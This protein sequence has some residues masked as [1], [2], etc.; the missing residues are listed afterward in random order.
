LPVAKPHVTLAESQ[1]N[2]TNQRLLNWYQLSSSACFWY[3]FDDIAEATERA[4][5]TTNGT[6]KRLI[7][8]FMFELGLVS[9]NPVQPGDHH[10]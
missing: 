10:E 4:K 9:C 5:F 7:A 1:L 3:Q 2:T 6:E 8:K